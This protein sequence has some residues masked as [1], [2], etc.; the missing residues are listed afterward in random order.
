MKV[1]HLQF[2][3]NEVIL[4]FKTLKFK[5][6]KLTFDYFTFKWFCVTSAFVQ[7]INF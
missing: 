7:M 6:L 2:R 5:N 1:I 3:T 4:N